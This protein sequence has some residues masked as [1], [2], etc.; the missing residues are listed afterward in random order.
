MAYDRYDDDLHDRDRDRD[1][2]RDERHRDH[3]PAGRGFFGARDRDDR[4]RHHD[5]PRRRYGRDDSSRVAVPTDETRDLIA[6]N[7]VEGTPV[8]GR[9]DQ[10]LGSIKTLMI[11]KVRGQ[12]RY[13]VLSHAT[14]FL[15]LDERYFPVQWDDLRYDE[16]RQGYR[17]DFTGEDVRYTL[18][19]REREHSRDLDRNGRRDRY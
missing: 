8:Y 1:R 13:A 9:D 7:K 11:D 18:D 17:V 15:G 6:S 2:I 5:E 19:K 10:R 14:G 4:E 12:V 3:R 16:R